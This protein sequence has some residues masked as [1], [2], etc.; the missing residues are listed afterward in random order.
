M[1]NASLLLD[2]ELV[3]RKS[4]IRIRKKRKSK[5]RSKRRRPL[6]RILQRG[7]ESYS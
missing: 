2:S 1:L 4:K 6:S 5:R 7:I 3:E